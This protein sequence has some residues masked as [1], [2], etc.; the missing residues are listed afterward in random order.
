MAGQ[1]SECCEL[2]K[3]RRGLS[4]VQTSEEQVDV[5]AMFAAM[6]SLAAAVWTDLHPCTLLL[7]AVLFL[8][9]AHFFKT[10]RQNNYPPGPPRLPILGNF[11]Q[12]NF[13][14]P[15]LSLQQVGAGEGAGSRVLSLTR[16][17]RAIPGTE[18]REDGLP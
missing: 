15:Q 6:G 11:F 9:L 8:V 17:K 2:N 16:R 18:G 12:L 3:E 13:E 7:G 14:Q 10:R 4:P 1:A 5:R